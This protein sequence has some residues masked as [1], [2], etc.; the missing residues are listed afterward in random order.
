MHASDLAILGGVAL[1]FFVNG[2]PGWAAAALTTG[3]IGMIGSFTRTGALTIG[4]LV[5]RHLF[6]ERL[7]RVG[8]ALLGFSAAAVGLAQGP[9]IVVAC[10]AS[11]GVI[12]TVR[13]VRQVLSCNATEV[14]ILVR[15][16]RSDSLDE[17]TEGMATAPEPNRPRSLR[18]SGNRSA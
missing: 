4:V 11:Y 3:A 2:H 16:P 18:L 15:H 10:F 7:F 9:K 6:A 14:G 1:H 5:P 12:E 17:V 8:G 13:V